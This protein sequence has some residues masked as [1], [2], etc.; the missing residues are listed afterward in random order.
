MEQRSSVHSLLQVL[1][2]VTV[3][4]HGNILHT[5]VQIGVIIS[6]ELILISPKVL[7]YMMNPSESTLIS[8]LCIDSLPGYWMSVML[9]RIK[10]FSFM[11]KFVSIHHPIIWTGLKTITPMLIST[12]ITVQLFPQFMNGITGG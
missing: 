9:Y 3:I 4:M 8:R 10:M 12:R 11:N 5:T 2:K 7:W 6:K 1:S